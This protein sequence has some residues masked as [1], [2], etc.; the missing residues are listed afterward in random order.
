[1]PARLEFCLLG[2]LA[3][4]RD[5][6][7]VPVP[8][9]KQ[10]ALLAVLLLR[11]GQPVTADQLA[12]LL[13]APAPPPSATATV[14][15]YIKRLRQALGAAGQDRIV[16]QPGGYLIRVD[17]GELDIARME[18]ELT[19]A[20]RAFRDAD[21]QRAGRHAGAA[22][23]LWRGEPLCDVDLPMLGEQVVPRLTELRLQA[24]ELRIEADLHLGRHAE[25]VAGLRE[26]AGDHPLREHLHALLMLALYRCGRRAEALEAYRQA[27]DVLVQEIG[28][29]PG[30]ELQALHRQI[31][32]DDPALSPPPPAAP[33]AGVPAGR[34]GQDP[35][36]Q[37]P[38]AVGCFTGREAELAMMT[39]LLS[40]RSGA[41]AP[42]M[43]ISAIGGTAGVGKTALAIQWAHQVAGEFPDGQLYVNLRGYDPGR[44]MPAS[45]ALAGFLAALGVPSPQI[46]A[47]EAGRAAAYRSVLAGRRVLIVLDNAHD[48][49]Q[50]RP[51]LPGEPGC[52]VVVTSRDTLAGLVARDGARRVLLDVLPPG[53]AVVL[54]RA[55]IGRRADA[56]PEA[57]ARLAGLCCCLPL[58]LRVAAELAAARPALSLAA[59]AGELDGQGRLDALQAGGDQATA[60]RAVFSWSCGY[61]SPGAARAFRL[62]G[63]HPGAD[64]DTYA[65]VALTGTSHPAACRALAELSR[66][67]LIHQADSDRYRMHDLLRA[68]AA[69]LASAQDPE[70]GRREALTRLFDHYL[71][72]AARAMDILFPAEAE[73][74]PRVQELA[75]PGP[76]VTDE[77]SARAWLATERANLVTAVSYTADHGWPTHAVSMAGILFRYLNVGGYF[78]EA[79]TVQASAVRSAALTGDR[80]A[81]A[82]A[83]I[84]LGNIELRQARY[85]QAVSNLEQA[86]TL[87]RL[88]ADRHAELN[89]LSSLGMINQIQGHY[90]LAADNFWQLL[91]LS[92]ATGNQS[93]EIRALLGLGT[94]AMLCGRYREAAGQLRQTVRMCQACGDRVLLAGALINLGDLHLRQGRYQQARDHFLQTMAVCRDT[95]DQVAETHAGCYLALADLRQGHYEQAADQFREALSQFRACGYRNGE[96]Q[97]LCHLGELDLRRGRYPQARDDLRQALNICGGTGDKSGEAEVLNLLAELSLAEAHPADAHTRHTQALAVACQIAD[98]YQQARAHRGLGNVGAA[99]GDPVRARY[100]WNEALALYTALE[101]PEADQIRAQLDVADNLDQREL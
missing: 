44:P 95:G 6:V 82:H 89:A 22:I 25:V 99:T 67:S 11:A 8:P 84:N 28:G 75:D 58:A 18:H 26:L 43:V 60:V 53:D 57:A 46:P 94:I 42:A 47:E 19:T 10:R 38:A 85:Q 27:R 5:G 100:H 77:P 80:A 68:Y 36:R 15:N 66:A 88:T 24:H 30:P 73:Q 70:G 79:A 96:A 51:L 3:V 52:L 41:C 20:R 7:A 12:E 81:Q 29:D 37:L 49:G 101:T 76:P 83:L 23:G 33:P 86:Q 35:P 71:H 93:R 1:M 2:P 64:F 87:C 63:L 74:R 9:G 17:D 78:S 98:P 14:R 48:A 32:H 61:L 13:W 40:R 31:L 90:S 4:R 92:R 56:E 91:D 16:T 97:A 34:R 39:G 65:V 62:A 69:E 55:L 21:W 59:L 72:A 54:L 45:E 50:V